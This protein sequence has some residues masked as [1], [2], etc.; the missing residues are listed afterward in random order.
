MLGKMAVSKVAKE[1]DEK[2]S[3]TVLTLPFIQR[4]VKPR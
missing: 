2:A 1:S 4:T 3:E